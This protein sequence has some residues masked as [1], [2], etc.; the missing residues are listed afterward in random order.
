MSSRPSVSVVA[1]RMGEG[2]RRQ[3]GRSVEGRQVGRSVEGRMETG[4][5]TPWPPSPSASG[6]TVT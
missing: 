4:T 2:Y 5:L 3:V 1:G 6:R